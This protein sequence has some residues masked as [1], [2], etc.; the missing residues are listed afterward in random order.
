MTVPSGLREID[1]TPQVKL[2]RADASSAGDAA[3]G[4][5]EGGLTVRILRG[6]KMRSTGS[7]FDEVAAALQFPHYFGENWPAFDECLS[8]MDWLLPCSGIVLLVLNAAKVLADEPGNELTT[9]IRVFA[10]ASREYAVE[11]DRGE[12]WDRPALPFHVVL[13]ATDEIAR[14]EDAWRTA[15]AETAMLDS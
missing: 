10:K 12:W 7:L 15:G 3:R 6:Q 8:D 5:A 4:W 14:L 2:L 11:I 1:E 9:L 13:Q